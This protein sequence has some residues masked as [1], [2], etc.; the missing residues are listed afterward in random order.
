MW[1]KSCKS[2][3]AWNYAGQFHGHGN[4]TSCAFKVSWTLAFVV[5]S[6]SF[7]QTWM[8]PPKFGAS[9][10][11]MTAE[12]GKISQDRIGIMVFA[13]EGSRYHDPQFLLSPQLLPRNFGYNT[14]TIAWRQ[15][16]YLSGLQC[17]LIL[18]KSYFTYLGIELRMKLHL[19]VRPCE[20]SW[21]DWT[22]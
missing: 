8:T 14:I 1:C 13:P 11:T 3:E 22:Y 19:I 12:S 2:K 10:V 15:K 17:I 4:R 18:Q 5:L 20:K 7:M 21:T 6:T 9:L 16:R